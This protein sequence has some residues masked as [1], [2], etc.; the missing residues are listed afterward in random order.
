MGSVRTLP[1]SK[2]EAKLICQRLER[3]LK[4]SVWL[5]FC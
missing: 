5:W 1:G 2:V 3:R 4:D